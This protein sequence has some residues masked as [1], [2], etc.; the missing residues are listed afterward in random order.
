[1]LS[2]AFARSK[3]HSI[4]IIISVVN[5]NKPIPNSQSHRHSTSPPSQTDSP[6]HSHCYTTHCHSPVHSPPARRPTSDPA[7]ADPDSKQPCSPYSNSAL[8]SHCWYSKHHVSSTASSTHA[9]AGAATESSPAPAAG[10]LFPVFHSDSDVPAIRE[11]L[12]TQ[13]CTVEDLRSVSCVELGPG[14]AVG[15][16]SPQCWGDE[17]RKAASVGWRLMFAGSFGSLSCGV[18]FARSGR[19]P[20]ACRVRRFA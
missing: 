19:G 15:S 3:H 13:A 2:F 9:A 11:L 17:R 4:N 7:A 14:E 12:C 20:R 6:H 1:M 18:G 16:L 8:L 5:H 10:H